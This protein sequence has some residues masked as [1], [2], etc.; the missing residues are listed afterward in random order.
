M[1]EWTG[2]LAL[3]DEAAVRSLLADAARAG[4]LAGEIIDTPKDELEWDKVVEFADI[5]RR[6]QGITKLWS[7]ILSHGLFVE[8]RRGTTPIAALGRAIGVGRTRAYQLIY[9]K[10]WDPGVERVFG[11]TQQR[12]S[13]PHVEAD[14]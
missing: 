12:R 5:A 13:N 3:E 6:S 14:D 4:R 10:H 2:K 1:T 8:A 7:T 9:G 11:T